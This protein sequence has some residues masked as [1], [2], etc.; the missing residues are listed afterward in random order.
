M[1]EKAENARAIPRAIWKQ[2]ALAVVLALISGYVDAYAYLKYHL[3][4]SFMSGNTT[5]AGLDLSHELGAAAHRLWPIASFV[6]GAFAGTLWL[7][8]ALRQ[9][10]RWL[11]ASCAGLLAIS[12]ASARWSAPSNAVEIALLAVAMGAMNTTFTHVGK[13]TIHLAYITGMLNNFAHHLALAMKRQPLSPAEGAWDTH[14]RRA[15]LL[16]AVWLGFLLGAVL[17]AVLLP[18]L[19]AWALVFPIAVLLAVAAFKRDVDTPVA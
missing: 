17:P 4:A 18:S 15:V 7:H 6:A 16:L 3:Y 2:G 9:P 11:F 10:S 14:G 1:N 12:L 19:Q 5:Q 13:Q 8:S